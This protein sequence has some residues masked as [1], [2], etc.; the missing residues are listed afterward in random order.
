MGISGGP[1]IIKANLAVNL[2]ATDRNS[3]TS[4]S[5]TWLDL[6]GNNRNF[7]LV[8]GPAFN[9][10][11][12]GNIVFDGVDDYAIIDIT[13]DAPMKIENFI[14]S[15]HTYELWF[16]LNSLNPSFADATELLQSLITWP[17]FHNTTAISR[18]SP[19][20]SVYL[21][22][23]YL[24]NSAVNTPFASSIDVTGTLQTG[25]WFC[26]H[27]I[28]DYSNTRSITYLNGTQL[29]VTAS[30]P[31]T[32]MTSAQGNPA[33]KI[34]LGIARFTGNYRW[35]LQNGGISAVRLYSR[36][37]TATEVLQNYNMQKTKYGR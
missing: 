10:G 3:Y 6:S 4:G 1:N 7:T 16:R 30:V 29:F 28:I 33:N 9:T 17:G 26:V 24:W 27:D 12:I 31:T 32:S 18:A 5:T 34:H 13:N 20:S 35:L 21:I 25:S 2:D 37:L 15:N 23:N 22:T 11:S 19:S 14:F 8:N 36:A